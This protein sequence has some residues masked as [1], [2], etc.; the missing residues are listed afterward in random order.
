MAGMNF[1][2]LFY[3]WTVGRHGSVT[4]AANELNVA[5]PTIS[6]QIRQLEQFFGEKLFDRT[7]KRMTLTESGQ[8]VM[9]YADEMF[10]L[11]EDMLRSL[12]QI[13]PD[14]GMP[15]TVGTADAVPKIIVRSV[16]VP[17]MQLEPAPLIICREW[18]ADQL[19]SELSMHRLDLMISDSPAAPS[20]ERRTISHLVTTTPMMLAAVPTL[21][22]KYRAGFPKSLEGAPFIMPTSNNA[23]RESVDRWFQS[24]GVKPRVV[25]E[26]EDRALLHY[27][28]ELGQGIIPV[29]VLS[30][31]QLRRQ[32]G[33]EK[34]GLMHDCHESYY[35]IVI[36]RKQQHPAVDRIVEMTRTGFRPILSV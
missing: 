26:A 2:H 35:A 33:I 21:A 24:V 11:S 27:V 14:Q 30:Y 36:E 23:M 18:R 17:V 16:L 22:R 15:L 8:A 25:L 13:G 19:L 20:L 7:G 34:I 5:Q 9:R 12:R 4:T 3:F 31:P 1:N 28:A 6:V 32:F 10:R 29:A